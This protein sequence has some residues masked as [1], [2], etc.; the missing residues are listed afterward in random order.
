MDYL[1]NHVPLKHP[2]LS[3]EE[4]V[5]AQQALVDLVPTTYHPDDLRAQRRRWQENPR[6]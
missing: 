1:L 2:H 4:L 5:A 6:P 3:R